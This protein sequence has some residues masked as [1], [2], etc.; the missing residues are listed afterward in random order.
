MYVA[1]SNTKY[2]RHAAQAA[3]EAEG[4]CGWELQQVEEQMAA[5][6]EELAKQGGTQA[7]ARKASSAYCLLP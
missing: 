5:L 6:D 1:A 4:K 2:R 3:E 7:P